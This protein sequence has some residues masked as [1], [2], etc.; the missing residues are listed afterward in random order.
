VINWR[1][2]LIGCAE[3]LDGVARVLSLGHLHLNT[4]WRVTYRL[5][6]AR[7]KERERVS[8]I[9]KEALASAKC[10]HEFEYLGAFGHV[11]GVTAR[12]R[13]CKC[14]FTAWPGTI[15][16]DEIVAAR[17]AVAKPAQIE[18]REG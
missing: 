18:E 2:M 1:A 14:R 12:C 7:F 8:K 9:I 13:I 5:E 6:I 3:I 11:D 4:S 10:E 15:H 16:Y 17:Y